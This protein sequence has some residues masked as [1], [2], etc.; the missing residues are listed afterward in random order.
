MDIKSKKLVFLG[1]SITEGVGTSSN[2][3]RYFELI[4]KKTGAICIGYGISG[5]RIARRKEKSEFES[6]DQWFNSRVYQLDKD[7]DM[8]FVFGGTNDF[9][10]GDA[11]L[12]DIE[13]TDEYTFYGA[14][15]T[16][17]T[18]LINRYPNSKI[19]I[20]TPLHRTEENIEINEY[21]FHRPAN[22]E[23]F[24]DVIKKVANK[25]SL[26]VFDMFNE[27]DIDPFNDIQKELYMPDGLHPSDLGNELIANYIIEKIQGL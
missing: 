22:L 18:N 10:H 27:V 8:I 25:Y 9:G 13:D 2:D 15:N 7:A 5:T 20:L 23:G 3:K 11:Q 14:L 26:I 1:D 6:F 16:L 19:V 17:F 21:G 4:G 12:G 24:V